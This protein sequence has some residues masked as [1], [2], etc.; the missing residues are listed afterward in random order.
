[1][2][3]QTYYGYSMAD[4]SYAGPLTVR[5]DP[6]D[7]HPMAPPNSTPIAPPTPGANQVVVWWSGAW[8]LKPDYRGKTVY[9]TVNGAPQAV[10]AIGDIPANTTLLQP[11]VAPANQSVLWTGTAWGL[12]PNY[13]GQTWFDANGNHVTVTQPGDPTKFTTPLTQT[14]T[15]PT[16][17]PANPTIP[18]VITAAQAKIAL[19]KAGLLTQVQNFIN[20]ST[21]PA[22]PI[23]WNSAPQWERNNPTML[24]LCTAIGFPS[25]QVDQLFAQAAQY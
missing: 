22:V 19:Q 24:A 13:V 16:I 1:M 21:D 14:W 25:T 20:A 8:M 23:F 15:P 10:T 18:A 7:G 6:L 5:L 17:V 2:T 3:D 12:Q 11:P 9:S 4:G